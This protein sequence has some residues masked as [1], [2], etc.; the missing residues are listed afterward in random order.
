MTVMHELSSSFQFLEES[1][2]LYL[3]RAFS[4]VKEKTDGIIPFDY[5]RKDVE[6]KSLG[7]LLNIFKK[8]NSNTELINKISQLVKERNKRIHRGY[9]IIFHPEIAHN[10]KAI[11]RL[12]RISEKVAKRAEECL[13]RMSEELSKIN[14]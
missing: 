12:I 7:K 14:E 4:I 6:D 11:E 10:E 1:L 13:H 8:F 2:K 9:L 3:D 5:S